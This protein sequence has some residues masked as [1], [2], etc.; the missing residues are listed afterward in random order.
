MAP[1]KGYLIHISHQLGTHEEVSKDL[2]EFIEVDLA[3]LEL[4]QIVH[5]SDLKL[6][7]GVE[8]LALIHGDDYDTA[9]V[10]VNKPKGIN[11]DEAAG[12]AAGEATDA[13]ASE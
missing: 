5:L 6:S 11:E 1:E 7:E 13:E 2:P 4:G 12:E 8:I 9:V 3:D 10:T